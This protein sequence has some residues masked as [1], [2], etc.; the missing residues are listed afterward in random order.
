MSESRGPSPAAVVKSL[1]REN[2]VVRIHDSS[3]QS[4]AHLL[5]QGLKMIE[6]TRWPRGGTLRFTGLC[7]LSIG[8]FLDS[9][10]QCGR[11]K[12]GMIGDST[13]TLHPT[14]GFPPALQPK[15]TG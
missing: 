4:I 6:Y 13:Q 12:V 5:T 15:S 11:K 8:R 2:D 7:V 9:G 3:L 14:A 10:E 1:H